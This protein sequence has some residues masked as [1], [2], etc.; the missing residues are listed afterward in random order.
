MH[1]MKLLGHVVHVESHFSP[2][3]TLLVMGQDRCTVWAER[4]TGSENSSGHT[5]ELLGGMGHVESCFGAF[6]D[7]ANLDVR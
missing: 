3:E 1:P 6:G 7:C 5:L 4:S 2:L